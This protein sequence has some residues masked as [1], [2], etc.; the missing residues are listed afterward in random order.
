MRVEYDFLRV[1]SV[2][3][4][5]RGSIYV[6]VGNATAPGVIDTHAE[7]SGGDAFDCTSSLIVG[8]PSL[9]T[10]WVSARDLSDT[11]RVVMHERPDYDCIASSFLVRRLLEATAEGRGRPE[12]WE[13]WAPVLARSARRIDRGET[14][15]RLSADGTPVPISPYMALLALHDLIPPQSSPAETWRRVVEHGHLVLQRALD[16]AMQSQEM[17]LERTDLRGALSDLGE[18]ERRVDAN[19]AAF[20]RD[21]ARINLEGLAS[22]TPRDPLDGIF[23]IEL[24]RAGKPSEVVPCRLASIV[25]PEC[26]AGFFKSIIR[27]AYADRIQATCVF[28][29]VPQDAISGARAWVHP[30][31]SVEQ[32]SGLDL[33]GLGRHLDSLETEARSRLGQPRLGPVR[34]GFDNSDPWYDGRAFGFTIV[35]AP[36]WG[37]VLHPTQVLV[38]IRD[39]AAWRSVRLVEV[40]TDLLGTLRFSG[41]GVARHEAYDAI[42]AAVEFW[43]R[44]GAQGVQRLYTRCVDALVDFADAASVTEALSSND[45]V[46]RGLMG[47]PHPEVRVA[48]MVHRTAPATYATGFGSGAETST[49]LAVATAGSPVILQDLLKVSNLRQE[50]SRLLDATAAAVIRGNADPA[51][52]QAAGGLSSRLTD[53]PAA[54][55]SIVHLTAVLIRSGRPESALL[56]PAAEECIAAALKQVSES[57]DAFELLRDPVMIAEVGGRATVEREIATGTSPEAELLF[58]T[59]REAGCEPGPLVSRESSDAPRSG[60]HAIH[61]RLR[62]LG[63]SVSAESL[64]PVVV[65][66]GRFLEEEPSTIAREASHLEAGQSLVAAVWVD[67]GVDRVLARWSDRAL[68]AAVRLSAEVLARCVREAPFDPR[69][70]W[71]LL[72]AACDGEWREAAAAAWYVRTEDEERLLRNVLGLSRAVSIASAQRPLRPVVPHRTVAFFLQVSAFSRKTPADSHARRALDAVALGGADAS[73]DDIGSLRALIVGELRHAAPDHFLL[74]D[75]EPQLA[76][77]EICARA[78]AV[79]GEPELAPIKAV[80]ELL[81]LAKALPEID[82]NAVRELVRLRVHPFAP[83]DRFANVASAAAG[84]GAALDSVCENDA[85]CVA[86]ERV[87]GAIARLETIRGEIEAGPAARLVAD[88][89]LDVTEV[90]DGHASVLDLAV[91]ARG[92]AADSMSL[93]V[94]EC[95]TLLMLADDYRAATSPES[96]VACLEIARGLVG[97]AALSNDGGRA[98]YS[99]LRV[100]LP[101]P[102]DAFSRIALARRLGEREPVERDVDTTF[103]RVRDLTA[104]PRHSLDCAY[105]AMVDALIARYA[106]GTARARIDEYSFER[107]S[108]L[109]RFTMSGGIAIIPLIFFGLCAAATSDAFG[110]S[111]GRVLEMWIVVIVAGAAA[112]LVLEWRRGTGRHECRRDVEA[113]R[114]RLF[115]PTYVVPVLIGV[116]SAGISDE[117]TSHLAL[118]IDDARFAVLT[119]GFFAASVWALRQ[120]IV[121]SGGTASLGNVVGAALRLFSYGFL[122]ALALNLVLAPL[123]NYE[124]WLHDRNVAWVY[125]QRTWTPSRPL[126]D[127][128]LHPHHAILPALVITPTFRSGLALFPRHLLLYA[129]FG[130]FIGIF[131]RGFWKVSNH[132]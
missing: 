13:A 111:A 51:L 21:A 84:V 99:S 57:N 114:Y 106:I 79:I 7:T 123:L 49:I 112:T 1:G 69:V 117:I 16:L 90:L 92:D 28:T 61:R 56:R 127:A 107:V 24:P 130:M 115:L 19:I 59:Y 81:R 120:M 11:V 101:S 50:H 46:F 68:V 2:V 104:L 54:W 60:A 97:A 34:P 29:T 86:P 67:A 31:V 37:T 52:V 109:L 116:Y 66:T 62:R 91:Q 41:P 83:D 55:R 76:R 102:G 20:A 122:I 64:D 132:E 5:T 74:R 105:A 113:L 26:G 12:G 45:E 23:A 93:A 103:G 129:M 77:F 126:A 80:A 73:V 58:S 89:I 44:H 121:R 48:A 125:E 110:E 14:R 42:A 30:I 43:Q 108:A 96:R 10:D 87:R 4:P 3:S 38:A 131:L 22:T 70:R 39:T 9:V 94:L 33:R 47:S 65:E 85:L 78:R 17:D 119:L 8:D 53:A 118:Q 35:D 40:V 15:I 32:D 128:E 27:G 82:W 25:D 71:L 95:S 100:A 63:R 72:A 124:V 36:R 98:A 88:L 18:F 75:A 6:D